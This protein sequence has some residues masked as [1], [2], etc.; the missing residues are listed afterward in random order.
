MSRSLAAELLMLPIVDPAD[1]ERRRL[2]E[3]T[4]ALEQALDDAHDD[5][6]RRSIRRELRRERFRSGWQI[7]RTRLRNTFI[8]W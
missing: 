4:D 3:R 1:G 8:P 5:E 2:R 7:A 6:E